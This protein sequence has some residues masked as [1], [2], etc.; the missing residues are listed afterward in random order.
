MSNQPTWQTNPDIPE[1]AKLGRQHFPDISTDEFWNILGVLCGE[2]ISGKNED[3][4]AYAEELLE[5]TLPAEFRRIYQKPLEL[6]E[7]FEWSERA[8]IPVGVL[9]HAPSGLCRPAIFDSLDEHRFLVADPLK[10]FSRR[11]GALACLRLYQAFCT[12]YAIPG[13]D[14]INHQPKYLSKE[15][16]KAVY[17][18]GGYSEQDFELAYS[19]T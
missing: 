11:A 7:V 3:G 4:W 12:T 5:M 15:E 16:V 1:L 6:W 10:P 8:T 17:L 18:Q 19:E 2:K 9:R 13:A 14:F